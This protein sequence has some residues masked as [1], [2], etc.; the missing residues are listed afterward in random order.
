MADQDQPPPVVI[1]GAQMDKIN[2]YIDT[3]NAHLSTLCDAEC[4]QN[5]YIKELY[6]EYMAA[7]NNLSAAP[8]E[9][10]EAEKNYYI[11]ER[12]AAWYSNFEM[13]KATEQSDADM[14]KIKSNL[15]N[16]YDSINKDIDYY[17]SQLIYRNR[18]GDMVNTQNSELQ[19]AIKE[20][21]DLD[22]KRNVANRLA[23][24]YANDVEWVNSVFYYTNLR[25]FYWIL[26]IFITIRV[27][28]KIYKRVYVG[29]QMKNPLLVVA[30]LLFMPLLLTPLV[31]F[32]I[33]RNRTSWGKNLIL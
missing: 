30:L 14:V 17:G 3:F 16:I 22:S 10:Q 2:N 13:S 29:W 7:K 33:R 28:W 8:V 5:Q 9:V 21:K 26:V 4:R 19:N 32:S 31:R 18:L 12:G 15:E 1:D 11:A 25:L 20:E 27:C 23:T 6:E 24:Y